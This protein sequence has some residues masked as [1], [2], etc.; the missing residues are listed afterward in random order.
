MLSKLATKTVHETKD[1]ADKLE[2][3]K[4]TKLSASESFL[5]GEFKISGQIG[6]PGQTGKGKTRKRNGGSG[7]AETEWRKRNRG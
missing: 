3:P 2:S 7:M 1:D 5:R 6:E 4:E